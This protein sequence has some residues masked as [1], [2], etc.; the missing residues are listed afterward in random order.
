MILRMRGVAPV[1]WPF[2]R[3]WLPLALSVLVWL[4]YTEL[5]LLTALTALALAAVVLF[6][7]FRTVIWPVIGPRLIENFAALCSLLV[8]LATSR[9]VREIHGIPHRFYAGDL[10][11]IYSVTVLEYLRWYYL[12][13]AAYVVIGAISCVLVVICVRRAWATIG[14]EDLDPLR[15]NALFAAETNQVCCAAL[16]AYV[17]LNT[18]VLWNDHA[19]HAYA[20]SDQSI[21]SLFAEGALFQRNADHTGKLLC[22][23]YNKEDLVHPLGGKRADIIRMEP[24]PVAPSHWRNERIDR[25]FD[26]ECR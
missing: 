10:P 18:V 8:F 7:P 11:Y 4:S 13:I 20:D 24:V 14:D 17:A 5:D 22:G 9:A 26:V 19:R 16:L 15:R 23:G 1:P 12:E 21:F 25:L 3:P 6:A 2:I